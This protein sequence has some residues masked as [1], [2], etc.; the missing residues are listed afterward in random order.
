MNTHVQSLLPVEEIGEFTGLKISEHRTHGLF[1]DI[2]VGVVE[3][4]QDD[5]DQ[6]F[7]IVDYAEEG[8]Q[9]FKRQQFDVW[10]WDTR[11]HYWAFGSPFFLGVDE[12]HWGGFTSVEEARRFILDRIEGNWMSA[13]TVRAFPDEAF[14]TRAR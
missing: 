14:R 4:W 7:V 1:M 12:P 8:Q 13:A 10:F 3:T 5:Y 2:D 9:A 6:V 11:E